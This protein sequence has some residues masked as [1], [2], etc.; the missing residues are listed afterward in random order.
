MNDLPW[1]WN[2][3]LAREQNRASNCALFLECPTCKVEYGGGASG[4]V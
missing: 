2:G 4:S 3:R 1:L